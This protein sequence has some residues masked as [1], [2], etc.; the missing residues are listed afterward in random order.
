MDTG[1][2]LRETLKLGDELAMDGPS[3]SWE[4]RKKMLRKILQVYQWWIKHEKWKAEAK[5]RQSPNSKVRTAFTETDL[6]NVKE[7]MALHRQ[8]NQHLRDLEVWEVN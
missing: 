8:M 3:G 5:L 1:I 4:V 2:L 6:A 7:A